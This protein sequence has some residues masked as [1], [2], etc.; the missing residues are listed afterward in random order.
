MHAIKIE[1]TVY[2]D[3]FDWEVSAT[4]EP[5]DIQD[6]EIECDGA[7]IDFDKVDPLTRT[8]V[9]DAISDALH[10]EIAERNEEARERRHYSDWR[11]G[12]LAESAARH[13]AAARRHGSER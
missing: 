6:I 2:V 11:A 7:S 13:E 5:D 8:H 3:G 1:T 4:C 9:L 12:D 10:L